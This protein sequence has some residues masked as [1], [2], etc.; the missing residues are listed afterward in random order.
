MPEKK[1]I[2]DLTIWVGAGIS[3][4]SPSCLPSGNRLTEFAFDQV[5]LGKDRFLKIWNAINSYEK[6][7]CNISTTRFPR[8]ELLLSSIAYIEKFFMGKEV[9]KGYFLSGLKAFD[10]V[11]FN[12]NHMLV[13]V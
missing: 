8:L 7:Y 5:I 4:E 6:R 1:D 11:P 2:K 10:Q 3:M 12:Q 9:L 13:A